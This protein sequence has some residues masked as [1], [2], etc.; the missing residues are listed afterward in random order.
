MKKLIA[1]PECKRQWD[2]TQYRVGQKLR[3]VCN[4]ILEVPRVLSHTP[5]IHHCAGC[6]GPRPPASVEPCKYCGAVPDRDSAN[7]TLVCPFCMHRITKG[8][9]FCS[10]C[11]QTIQPGQLD[12][13]TGKLVCP[14]CSKTRLVNR[15]VGDF[16]VDECPTCS[17]LWV[18]VSAF[19]RIIN[20]QA[21]REKSEYRRGGPSGQPARASLT[22]EKVVYLKCPDCS[23]HMHRRN[24]GRASGVIIDE[25]HDHGVWLDCD[26]L[27]K[28]AAF[29]ASGGVAFGRK[30]EAE[31]A[32]AGKP[33][34]VGPLPAGISMLPGGRR[35]EETPLGSVIEVIRFLF[36]SI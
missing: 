11:G 13:K 21:E 30:L 12:A 28:I 32:A 35:P 16:T 19:D 24:F 8:S 2:V 3:C 9:L 5:E 6:G 20:Q 14:R 7:L 22:P 4:E 1:C 34:G 18:E 15:K 26:E 33:T 31:E 23:R 25:C 27:G 10:S 36:T 29:V 17:G